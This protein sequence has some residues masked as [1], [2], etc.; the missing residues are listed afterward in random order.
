MASDVD[1][2]QHPNRIGMFAAA[3]VGPVV[4]LAI[5]GFFVIICIRKRRKERQVTAAQALVKEMKY[6]QPTMQ[7]YSVPAI[8]QTR[9]PSYTAPSHDPPVLPQPS[10][11]ILGPIDAGSNSA[12]MTGIDTSDVMS[13]RNERTGLGDPFADGSSMLEEPPPPYQP[14]SLASRNSVRIPRSSLSMSSQRS[15]P[16][17][18]SRMQPLGNPFEDPREDDAVSQISDFTPGNNRDN[19]SAVSDLSY[20]RDSELG[21]EHR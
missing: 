7:A 17:Y 19:M 1:Q 8:P 9:A 2:K 4:V 13:T 15:A 14:R 21:R 16:S 11:V 3:G 18:T 20:Q 10:P 6:Q 5:I 12:Y